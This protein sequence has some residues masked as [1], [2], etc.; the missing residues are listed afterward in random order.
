MHFIVEITTESEI[1]LPE[2]PTMSEK[3]ILWEVARNN[4]TRSHK[5]GFTQ[6]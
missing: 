2:N 5:I 3:F 4:N 6:K 1:N